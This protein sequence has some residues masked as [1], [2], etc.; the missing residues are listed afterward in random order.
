MA[1]KYLKIAALTA[2]LS[3]TSNVHALFPDGY[4][5]SLNGKSGD[6]LKAAVKA[7]GKKGYKEISYG[8]NTWDAFS[9]TDV[10]VVNGRECWWD[11]YSAN[12][13]A[14][15]SGHSGLNIEHS[16]ANSWWGGTKNNAYKD[17][18]HLNPSDATANNRKSNYPLGELSTVTWDNEITFVGK[19]KSGMEGGSNNYSYEPHDMYKGDFA[20][21][22]MYM[23]VVYDDMSWR[24]GDGYGA[25]YSYTD[26]KAEFKPWAYNML[27]KWSANDP[28]GE[29]EL[30]R[31]DGIQK[32]QGN[33]NP[34]IDLPD[35]ADYI[36]GAKKGQAYT[37]AG[38]QGGNPDPDPDPDPTPDPTPGVEGTWQLVTADSQITDRHKYIIVSMKSNNAM[39]YNAGKTFLEPTSTVVVPENDVVSSVPS[40]IAVVTISGTPAACQLYV[41]DTDGVGK[42]Y[43]KSEAAKSVTFTQTGG[44]TFTLSVE[45]DGNATIIAAGNQLLYNFSSP[46]F[47]TYKSYGANFGEYLSLYRLVEENGGTSGV[48][49]TD[50]IDNRDLVE[51][52]GNNILVPEGAVIYD[53]N[54]RR[55]RGEGVAKGIY[56]VNGPGFKA[57]LKVLVK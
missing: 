30:N 12:N 50:T 10:R 21:A 4:Y 28:V 24:T 9:V 54:G 20:R 35:L 15:S 2:A 17:I 43:L 7:I 40:D 36:W 49:E 23:F 18:V 38:N 22:F 53:L 39:S 45:A 44:S 14:V 29:K 32:K 33:R 27:I 5:D 13:V 3:V 19:P 8:D 31:N 41:S 6:A 56:I 51:V 48:E 46:R 52:W 47:T 1:N 26:G 42:G 11:M 34:F 55:V 57:P 16:V 37:V 25:M